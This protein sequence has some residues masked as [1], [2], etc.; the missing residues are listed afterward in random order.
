MTPQILSS[1]GAF[2]RDPH[3][4]DPHLIADRMRMLDQAGYEVIFYTPW[5]DRVAEAAAPIRATGYPI[6]VVHAHKMIGPDLSTGDADDR[7]RARDSFTQNLDLA[8]LL[9]ARTLVLHLWGT[10]DIEQSL[11]LLRP[12]LHDLIDEAAERDV[13]VSVETIPVRGSTPLTVLRELTDAEPR[14]RVTVDTEFLG[15]HGEFD[16]VAEHPWLWDGTV[17]HIQVKDTLGSFLDEQGRRPYLHPGEGT[18][19]LAGFFATIIERGYDGT[20]SLESTALTDDGDVN[21]ARLRR[22]LGLLESWTG[23]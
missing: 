7:A 10:R 21:W 12:A 16:G 13:D 19:D 4:A 22:S 2:S 1:T 14:A 9:G 20:V 15:L 23:G 8:G 11:P 6:P 3:V 18:L 5:F 17:D